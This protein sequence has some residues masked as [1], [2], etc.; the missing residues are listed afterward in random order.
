MQEAVK[1]PQL[2]EGLYR[3]PLTAHCCATQAPARS[4][5]IS[6]PA[7]SSNRGPASARKIAGEPTLSLYRYGLPDVGTRQDRYPQPPPA[8]DGT[9]CGPRPAAIA[10]RCGCYLCACDGPCALCVVWFRGMA[11]AGSKRR[12]ADTEQQPT[13]IQGF[14]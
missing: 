6:T 9:T 11:L 3:P 1:R 14:C 8:A 10:S 13:P 5:F 12:F 4:F 7:S 2:V